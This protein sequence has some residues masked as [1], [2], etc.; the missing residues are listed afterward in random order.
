MGRSSLSAGQ[1]LPGG[2][3]SS[4]IPWPFVAPQAAQPWQGCAPCLASPAFSSP[5]HV[6]RPLIQPRPSFLLRWY[7]VSLTLHSAVGWLV[8][9][10][11][12][13]SRALSFH[14]QNGNIKHC[15]GLGRRWQEGSVLSGTLNWGQ[16]LAESQPPLLME[17]VTV[18]LWLSVCPSV[19]PWDCRPGGQRLCLVAKAA[20]SPAGDRRG[21]DH[22]HLLLVTEPHC[23]WEL[24]CVLLL[25][26]TF[27]L[28]SGRDT[29]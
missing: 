19:P 3:G 13:A 18:L 24:H 8:F 5:H 16:R 21:R 12:L 27:H 22:R 15:L 14:L 10:S 9:S 28:L 23:G 29:D 4:P 11:K 7:E 20:L 17:H 26:Y 2:L 25:A 6:P 1:I